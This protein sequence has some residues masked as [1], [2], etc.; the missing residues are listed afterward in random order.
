MRRRDRRENIS[1]LVGYFLERSARRLGKPA[2]DSS[3]AT[4]E[5]LERYDWPGNVRELENVIE[6]AVITSTGKGL[7]VDLPAAS[8]PPATAAS[9]ASTGDES[10][11]YKEILTERQ[12]RELERDNLVAALR[13]SRWK[14][15]GPGGAAERLDIKPTTLASRIRK[16]GIERPM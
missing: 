1:P 3:R 16:L 9:R 13:R 14:L 10:P 8:R 7:H 15:A 12:M 4:C 6:R 11:D 2:P 5:L